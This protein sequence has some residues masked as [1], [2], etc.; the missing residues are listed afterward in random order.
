MASIAAVPGVAS[1]AAKRRYDPCMD[2]DL[3]VRLEAKSK[4]ELRKLYNK[5]SRLADKS[6][7]RFAG[8]ECVLDELF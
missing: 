6:P 5:V 8:R 3:E 7:F 4:A 2:L 1:V